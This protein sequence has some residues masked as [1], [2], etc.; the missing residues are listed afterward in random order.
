MA[1]PN[2]RNQMAEARRGAILQAAREEFVAKGFAAAR[3]ED[4]ARRAGVAKGT[5]YLHFPD[6]EQLFGEVVS[7]QLAPI[8]ERIRG[9]LSVGGPSLRVIVEPLLLGVLQEIAGPQTGAVLRLLISEAVRF[10]QL[11]ERYRREVV[12]P[13]LALQRTLLARAAEA[14]EL[15]NPDFARFPQLIVAPLVMGVIWQA[16]F[17]KVMPLDLE[18]MLRTHLDTVFVP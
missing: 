3:V 7:A 12:E 1:A 16:L 14:G 13:M 6:K 10:P 18:A 9:S 4:I 15:R 5:I 11:A 2:R 8:A 17:G